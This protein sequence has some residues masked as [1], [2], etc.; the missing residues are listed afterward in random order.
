MNAAAVVLFGPPEREG[1]GR[2]RARSAHKPPPV[3]AAEIADFALGPDRERSF[4]R[5]LKT[6]KGHRH[7]EVRLA[8]LFDQEGASVGMIAILSDLTYRHH[9]EEAL[10]ESQAR[11]HAL[12]KNISVP[13]AHVRVLLDAQNHPV[14]LEFLEVNSAYEELTGR[15]SSESVGKRMTGIHPALIAGIDQMLPLFAHVART[16]E[17]AIAEPIY[18]PTGHPVTL[19]LYCPQPGHVAI[20]MTSAWAGSSKLPL[21]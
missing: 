13:W 20:L 5:E 9:S 17:S 11:Y 16:G 12:V 18:A 15:T 4:E 3:L 2:F 14:D 10:R 8:K 1:A 6:G 19:V 7:F 21:G